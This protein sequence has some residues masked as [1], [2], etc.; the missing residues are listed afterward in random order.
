MS[1]E[2]ASLI[3]EIIGGIAVF[4]SL[5]YVGIGV[6]QNAQAI[7]L[8]TGQ[9]ASQELRDV[10]AEW[11]NPDTASVVAKGGKDPSITGIE[12]LQ[13][14]AVMNTLMRVIEN[15]YFQFSAG[16]LDPAIWEG[17]KRNYVDVMSTAGATAWWKVR[18]SWFSEE[19]QNYFDSEVLREARTNYQLADTEGVR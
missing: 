17:F 7:R 19:F 10:V 13:F 15:G 6:R 2:Q 8:S 12:K 16:T 11:V 4:L 18:K 3:A 9:A 1:L 14:D 5:I